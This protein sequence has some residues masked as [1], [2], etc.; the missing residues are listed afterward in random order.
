MNF[1]E[2]LSLYAFRRL[3]S[4]TTLQNVS[5]SC[6][7]RYTVICNTFAAV[8]SYSCGGPP[9]IIHISMRVPQQSFDVT[10]NWYL[11]RLTYNSSISCVNATLMYFQWLVSANRLRYYRCWEALVN[12]IICRRDATAHK[13][14]DTVHFQLAFL[15]TRAISLT[16]PAIVQAFSN[17]PLVTL[18][19]LDGE[20]A[21]RQ[22]NTY[23]SCISMY[24][25][26]TIR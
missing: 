13:Y 12:N 20:G 15:Q 19:L 22:W 17:P 18:E 9:Y 23:N 7:C 24:T 6:W 16:T 1:F 8:I 14:L 2:T 26:M 21:T 11:N 10:V 5:T 4:H 25:S 3:L